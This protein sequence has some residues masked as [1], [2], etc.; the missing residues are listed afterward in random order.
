[1]RTGLEYTEVQKPAIELLCQHLGYEYLPGEKLKRDN[2]SQVLLVDRLA[3]KLRG[4]NDELSDSGIRDA[5]DALQKPLAMNLLEANEACHHAL[6]RWVTVDQFK[7]GKPYGKSVYFFDFDNISKNEFLVVDELEVKGPTRTRFLDLVVFVNGIP[8]VVIECKQP[9]D[10]HGIAKAADDLNVYQD[11]QA[12]VAEAVEDLTEFQQ[13]EEGVV[14]LFHTV[15]LTIALKKTDAQYGTVTTP[16]NRYAQWK[17]SYPLTLYQLKAMLSGD[18]SY[19][20]LVK[21]WAGQYAVSNQAPVIA[22]GNG[23]ASGAGSRETQPHS[24]EKEPTAQDVLLSGMLAPANLLDLLRNFVAFDR[25]DGKVVK[26]VARYQQFEAVNRTM[27][28]I[29]NPSSSQARKDRG[30]VIWHTQGSGKSLTMLWLCLKL[31]RSTPLENPT[32]VIVTDRTDLDRQITETFLNCGFENPVRASRVSHLRQIL[33]GA[34]GQTVMTTVQKF[35]EEVDVLSE[36]MHPRL[37]TADNVF[38]LIDEVHR[39]EY[40]QFNAN[41]RRA[42]PEA[43]L[44]G[45]TGT[46]VPQ[47]VL[48]FGNYIHT[49]TMPQSVSDGA[50][51]PILY[52]ARDVHLEIWGKIDL[53]PKF[54]KEFEELTPEQRAKL[55]LG[56]IK[57]GELHSRIEKIASD[58][59]AHYKENMEPDGFK[60]MVA[61]SSQRAALFYHQ[62]LTEHLD[63]RVATL[64]SGTSDKSSPIN[65][66]RDQ[67][68]DEETIIDDFKTKGVDSWCM[69]VVVDKYLTGFDAPILRALYLDKPLRDHGLLQAIARVNRPMPEKG[70]AWGLV[71]DYW[72]VASHLEQAMAMFQHDIKMDDVMRSRNNEASHARLR[73]CRDDL[74]A[75][76]PTGLSREKIDPWI[77]TLEPEDVRAVFAARYKLFYQALEQLLPDE[78]AVPFLSDFAWFRRIRKESQNQFQEEEETIDKAFSKRVDDF[79]NEHVTAEEVAVLLDRVNVLDERFESELEKLESDRAKASR[80]EHALKKT[81]TIHLHEDPVFFASLRERLEGVLEKRRQDRIDDLKKLNLLKSIRHEMISGQTESAGELGLTADSYAIYGLLRTHLDGDHQSSAETRD[82][83]Q[84]VFDVL[85]SETVIDWTNKQDVQREMRRKI[86][87][88]LRLANCKKEMIDELTV[89]IMDL[90]RVRMAK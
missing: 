67:F 14:R 74:Q 58:I 89:E 50:T 7:D 38:V 45:F 33:K 39:S 13:N 5:I 17:N 16:V 18:A 64:L 71:V 86:K 78:R 34:T 49:Y 44:I 25:D 30:G 6:S 27:D 43:C 46:P 69:L 61:C 60:G 20:D 47:T 2:T 37:S 41:L 81:I 42:L 66:L 22:N 75:M 10:P 15:L 57:H 88:S 84:E 48:H 19:P 54:D 56:T 76:F 52:E 8:L 63:G 68:A 80:M 73:H 24:G 51:V 31:R 9:G 59:A 72:G 12:E 77:M 36:T 26:K 55:K 28:Q 62:K 4:I 3:A 82:L 87:R 90:A 83:A 85:K 1:M 70:K 53:D 79:I 11:R 29:T 65:R 32:L 35:R 21:E 40:G 23:M